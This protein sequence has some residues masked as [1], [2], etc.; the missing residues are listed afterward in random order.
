MTP[1]G[2]LHLVEEYLAFRRGLG[3]DLESAGWKLRDF[4]RYADRVAHQGPLTT[5]L[6]VQWALSSHSS[7]PAHAGRR[8]SVLRPFARHRAAFDPGTEIPPVGLLGPRGRRKQPHVYEDQE[9]AALLEQASLLLPR[10]GLRPR[11]YVAYFSL[12]ASTGL[13]LSEACHLAPGD[14]D[15]VHGILTVRESKFRK[16]RL[17]PLHPTATEALLRYAAFRDACREAP[18]SRGFFHT[19]RAAVLTRAAVQTTFASLRKRL[20]WTAHG[21]ARRPR[22]HDLRHTFVV[23][24]LQRWYE[25]GAELDRKIHALAT[26][27]GHAKVT[28]TYWYLSAIPELMAITSQRF[29]RFA[30]QQQDRR[31]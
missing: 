29:E 26:Y 15:L 28:D 21:R 11:T 18:P 24:R 9:V 3:F 4:G 23:R 17:V 27:L 5:D 6:A 2:M 8:L 30:R 13:R 12:L 20:G 25:D 1:P 19:H 7:D 16:S 10:G 14:V 31:L 22:I